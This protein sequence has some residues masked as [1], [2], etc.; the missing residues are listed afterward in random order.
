MQTTRL[1]IGSILLGLGLAG[2]GA[3]PASAAA[4][5]GAAKF[6]VTLV[7]EKGPFAP[8]HYLAIWVTDAEGKLVRTLKACAKPKRVPVCLRTWA[9]VKDLDAISGATILTYAA[10]N[11]PVEVEWDGRDARGEVAPDGEYRIRVEFTEGNHQGPV[12]PADALR[13][14]KGPAAAR[15]NFADLPGFKAMTLAYTPR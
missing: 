3:L 13:F 9:A 15:V 2:P 11:N 14:T 10:P 6:T 8:R 12:T 5:E 7:P 4:T 1:T